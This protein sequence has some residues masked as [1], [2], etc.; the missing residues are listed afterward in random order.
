LALEHILAQHSLAHWHD[1]VMDWVGR[2]DG[3]RAT[4]HMDESMQPDFEPLDQAV[5]ALS[6]LSSP[7]SDLD[8]AIA[9]ANLDCT[10]WRAQSDHGL[11]QTWN[12]LVESFLSFSTKA[13]ALVK[14]WS[15]NKPHQPAA[16]FQFWL[17]G[18]LHAQDA[19]GPA[20]KDSPDPAQG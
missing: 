15:D 1:L 19:G 13:P 12:P 18:R 2:F 9:L 14:V 8:C 6:K 10:C 4:Y 16:V 7:A 5:N 11:K 17:L 3:W 20:L